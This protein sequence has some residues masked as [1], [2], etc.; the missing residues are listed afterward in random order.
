[1]PLQ[2]S[3][4][5][6]KSCDKDRT[7][8]MKHVQHSLL[9]SS[10]VGV[11][12]GLGL[13]LVLGSFPGC[14]PTIAGPIGGELSGD[15]GGSTQAEMTPREPSVEGGGGRE[16]GFEPL[17]PDKPPQPPVETASEPIVNQEPPQP[18]DGGVPEKNV[19]PESP[20]DKGPTPQSCPTPDPAPLSQVTSWRSIAIT[21]QPQPAQLPACGALGFRLV[22]AA[23]TEL[24]V[25]ISD[26]PLRGQFTL[27]AHNA[28][29]INKSA[30]DPVLASDTLGGKTYISIKV[31]VD[32]SGEIG[33]VLHGLQQKLPT[34]FRIHVFCTKN[35]QLEAT[36]YPIVLMHGFMGTDKYFGFLDY[37]YKV[38]PHLTKKGYAAQATKVQAIAN[39][40]QRIKVLK[41]QIDDIFKQ[42]GA[43]KL[44]LIAHSQGG[45]D[46]RLLIAI[47]KYG[48][49]IASLTTI[50][51]PHRG[52]PIPNLGIPP[53]GELGEANMKKYN[54]QY[55]NDSRV[56]YFSWAGVSC[57]IL[58]SQCRKKYKDETIDPLLIA[59][60]RTLQATRGPN[61]GIVTVDSAKW[62]TF[63][64]EIP[65][66]HFDEIGQVADNNNKAFNH[67]DFYL[68]EAQRL[69]KL[70]F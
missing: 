53:S 17:G 52:V 19:L 14:D 70:D 45:V 8:F 11:L 25:D 42:T 2:I 27:E 36:R 18:L 38:V 56:K 55:P 58:D 31:T 37:F 16:A 49:R 50:S 63:L 60:Y 43:R 21:A 6:I 28:R 69:K 44:N 35:C 30:G 22:A 3:G 32:R 20:A 67:L 57:A 26:L 13:L 48:D 15:A 39:S 29:N 64:G 46:G 9:F 40:T 61:D 4:I 5:H 33:L 68:Q 41:A 62:G 65:A 7:S 10:R 1:M 24:Q 51:T 12:L 66:D 59:T 23:K 54:Q 34:T 47:H